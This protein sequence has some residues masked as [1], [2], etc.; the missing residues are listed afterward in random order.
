MHVAVH[1]GSM[2][3]PLFFEIAMDVTTKNA[4]DGVMNKLLYADDLALTSEC[5]KNLRK[6]FLK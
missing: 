5:I 6:R 1:Q 4:R 3:S 2:L